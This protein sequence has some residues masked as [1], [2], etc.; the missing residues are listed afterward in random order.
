MPCDVVT[1]VYNDQTSDVI[2]E[3]NIITFYLIC[4]QVAERNLL[5][6]P[7]KFLSGPPIF[8]QK[9]VQKHFPDYDN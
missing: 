6:H 9:R 2:S 8:F 4:E 5:R 3:S 7:V 1:A